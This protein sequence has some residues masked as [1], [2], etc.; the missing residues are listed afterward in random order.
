MTHSIDSFDCRASQV[1]V[2]RDPGTSTPAQSPSG[3]GPSHSIFTP[4]APA[5]NPLLKQQVSLE[6]LQLL[7]SVQ[8][9]PDG[10]TGI[11]LT[12]SLPPSPS[13]EEQGSD[14]AQP[15]STANEGGPRIVRLVALPLD[16]AR[17]GSASLMLVLD[18][19]RAA[20]SDT[21]SL[22]AEAA[23]VPDVRVNE[24]H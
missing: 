24:E 14:P 19:M 7:V 16:P 6:Q 18:N 15:T 9:L 13:T 22:K 21:A 3:A 23:V 1:M 10:T 8:A 5:Y 4:R 2:T 17:P 12:A 20:S 11:M